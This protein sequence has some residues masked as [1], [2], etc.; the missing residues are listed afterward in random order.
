MRPRVRLLLL[1]CAA[2]AVTSLAAGAP[3]MLRRVDSFRV[4]RVEIRGTRYLAPYD[5][6]MQTGITRT[7]NVF[8]DF[9]LWQQ[10]LLR[11]PLVLE[12]KIE[13]ALPHTIKVEITEA[14]PIAFVRAP[15]L[16]AIDARARA[17]PIDPAAIDFD[18]PVLAFRSNED[19]EGYFR[20]AE[21]QQAVAMLNMLRA[22]DARLYNWISEVA[23]V[24]NEGMLL[25]L[26]QPNG[27]EVLVSANP[28]AVRLHEL[29][30]ALADLS[31]RGELNQLKSID[32]RFR[33]Q[34]VV[35][36]RDERN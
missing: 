1:G 27:A 24:A 30:I 28:R 3:A 5:A 7:S 16:R 9:A 2:C 6:L 17:L 21:T 10:R 19:A 22:K 8:D 20:D 18:L 35:S 31:A 26:R 33:D 32:A 4:Q 23:P 11:H 29:E 13:R 25:R 15:D 12:A 36:L 34:I 14:E